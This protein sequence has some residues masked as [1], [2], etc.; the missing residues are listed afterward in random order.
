MSVCVCECTRSYERYAYMSVYMNE[1]VIVLVYECREYKHT[2]T[3]IH[4]HTN[5]HKQPYTHTYT[6]IYT[7]THTYIYTHTNSHIY[8]HENGGNPLLPVTVPYQ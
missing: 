3:I 4:T 5:T 8:I 7:H 1:Y 2:Q 6:Y